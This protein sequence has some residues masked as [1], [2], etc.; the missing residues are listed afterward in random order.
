MNALG[1]HLLACGAVPL[2]VLVLG[3]F[4][5]DKG[6]KQRLA[7]EIRAFLASRSS[8]LIQMIARLDEVLT[9]L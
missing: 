8:A 6:I 5:L 2:L 9:S 7:N 1:K 4:A 3:D